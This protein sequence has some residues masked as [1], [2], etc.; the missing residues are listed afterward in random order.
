MTDVGRFFDTLTGFFNEEKSGAELQAAMDV[1]FANQYKTRAATVKEK[2]IGSDEFKLQEQ[3][4]MATGLAYNERPGLAIEK[5]TELN[6]TTGDKA[7]SLSK[8]QV[9]LLDKI[10]EN[11]DRKK[12]R[13]AEVVIQQQVAK[14]VNQPRGSAKEQ[15][16]GNG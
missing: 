16:N 5:M 10:A 1:G 9:E 11:T 7:L 8:Q 13:P 12:Q 15:E 3:A 6:K 14:N 2:T 4:K